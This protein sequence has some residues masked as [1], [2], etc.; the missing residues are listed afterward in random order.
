MLQNPHRTCV[1]LI[2]DANFSKEKEEIEKKKLSALKQSCTEKDI[3]AIAAHTEY[4]KKL[5]ETP[6]SAEA[7]ATIPKLS[8]KDIG[9]KN[10]KLPCAITQHQGRDILFHNLPTNDIL[11]LDLGFDL[12]SIPEKLLPLIPLFGKAILGM[13]TKKR[14]YVEL[15]QV[16]GSTTGGIETDLILSTHFETKKTVAQFLLRGK[17]LASNVR[18]LIEL[19]E[20][21]R[22][23]TRF[24]DP[25]RLK[26]LA[27][28][29]KTELEE[30][31]LPKGHVM[32]NRRLRSRL[33]TAGWLAELMNGF[34]Q[35]LFIR[36][37]IDQ[38]EIHGDEIRTDLEQL[39]E[40]LFSQA[41]VFLNVTCDDELFSC[42]T[43]FF[44]SLLEKIPLTKRAV[45]TWASFEQVHPEGFSIP[46]Q[47]NY[48]GKA[49]SLEKAGYSAHGSALVIKNFLHTN[50]FWD[51]VRVRGGAY[52]C[53]CAF[54]RPS[55]ILSFF[56]Y[57][58]PN[59][60]KTLRIFDETAQFLKNADIAAEETTKSII[61]TIG[62][63]DTYL[64]PQEKGYASL[65]EYLTG[66]TKERRQKMRDEILGSTRADFRTLGEYLEKA[67][68]AAQTVVLGSK[69][70]IKKADRDL[71]EKISITPIL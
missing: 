68:N 22:T 48:V 63:I 67:A 10:K 43:P 30:Q 1:I 20:E 8:L 7:L 39:R 16:I 55:G 47:V 58:D 27:L 35:I 64:L 69:E 50:W 53:M 46:S 19:L 52:G 54:D 36:K 15:S 60:T 14:S 34:E 9:R 24:T 65:I 62:D 40:I 51:Q 13:D 18:S 71:A 57:R 32:L 28:Q 45:E 44:H 6:D 49:F 42:T 3:Q 33:S 59:L 2:P 70:A 41:E 61:G 29:R 4:L 23:K 56:S 25:G 66:D 38:I 5:R 37:L 17:C 12:G 31:L 26:Q 21:I 11:Y